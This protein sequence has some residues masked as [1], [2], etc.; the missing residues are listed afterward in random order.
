[1]FPSLLTCFQVFQARETFCRLGSL[2]QCKTLRFVRANI[3]QK[4]F[5]DSPRWET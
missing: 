1:M 4:C 2:K 5:L 3:S